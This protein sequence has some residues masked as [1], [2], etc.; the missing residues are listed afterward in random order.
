MYIFRIQDPG[1]WECSKEPGKWIKN[2][3]ITFLTCLLLNCGKKSNEPMWYFS[4]LKKIFYSKCT[5][6]SS[7]YC[8]NSIFPVLKLKQY[9]CIVLSFRVKNWKKQKT[10]FFP[11]WKIFFSCLLMK[12]RIQLIIKSPL[13]MGRNTVLMFKKSWNWS[14]NNGGLV[15]ILVVAYNIKWMHLS[16]L[17]SQS[18]TLNGSKISPI[19]CKFTCNLEKPSFGRTVGKKS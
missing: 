12:A 19:P 11:Q 18:G 7:S 13:G 8:F 16:N 9:F 1:H 2:Y 4:V 17:L 14:W 6:H 10:L 3:C 5:F 15:W